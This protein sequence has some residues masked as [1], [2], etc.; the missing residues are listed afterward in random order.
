MSRRGSVCISVLHTGDVD[1]AATFYESLL[2]WT[3][4]PVQSGDGRFRFLQ[5]HGDT[6]AAIHGSPTLNEWVPHVSVDDGEVTTASAVALGGEVVSRDAVAE[7][8]RLTVLRDREGARFGLWQPSP[9]EG[10]T[11]TDVVGSL[12]W[13][14]VLSDNPLIAKEFYSSLFGWS[15]RETAFEPFSAYTVFER[16]GAQEGG[17]LPIGQDWGVTPR[18]NSIFAVDDCDATMQRGCG[19]GG[20]AGFVHTV[21][22]YGRLGSLFDPTGALICLRG[23]APE[24]L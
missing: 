3:V 10:A 15:T 24:A 20:A 13:A 19:L 9:L 21:P 4:L 11:L 23:P 18:W 7:V 16:P 2:G 14:E 12:W 6:V 1:R 17:V 8:V 22:K 5:W